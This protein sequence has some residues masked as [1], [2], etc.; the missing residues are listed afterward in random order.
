MIY[1]YHYVDDINHRNAHNHTDTQMTEAKGSSRRRLAF[2]SPPASQCIACSV[3]SQQHVNLSCPNSWKD[4]DCQHLTL[5]LGIS[6]HSIVCHPC[7]NDI[8]RLKTDPSHCPRREKKKISGCAFLSLISPCCEETEISRPF[9]F[10]HASEKWEK[11]KNTFF[12]KC[13]LPIPDITQCLTV[14]GGNIPPNLDTFL[15][16]CKHHYRVVYNTYRKGTIV[17]V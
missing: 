13:Y 12:S 8:S 3:C 15:P 16:L 11:S 5:S 2:T 6:G 1:M 17:C 4:E 9:L 10:S 7:R 14:A